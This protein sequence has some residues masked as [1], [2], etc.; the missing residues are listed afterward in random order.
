MQNDEESIVLKAQSGDVDAFGK[1]YEAYF[2]RIYRYIAIKVGNTAEAED[3]TSDVFLKL[4]ECIGLYKKRKDAS[5]SSWL[6]RLAH[7]L[8]IDHFRRSA[9]RKTEPFSGFELDA[10]QDI[11]ALVDRKLGLE[12]LSR[13]MR[14]LTEA[15][16]QVMSL[17]F[18]AQLSIAQTAEVMG[19]SENAIKALQHG[20]VATLRR[21]VGKDKKAK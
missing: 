2:D 14:G 7:N 9:R 1:L 11:E 12:Q 3:L 13:A 4:I 8:V 20:A 6:F 17:R 18:G 21:M 5:F 19:K 10:G 15:Q 16:R